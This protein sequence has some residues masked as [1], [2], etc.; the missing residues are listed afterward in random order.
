MAVAT[1]AEAATGPDE[2]QT[3]D[4]LDS[5]SHGPQTSA[6]D[7]PEA[8][9]PYEAQHTAT[10]HSNLSSNSNSGANSGSKLLSSVKYVAPAVAAL[11]SAW[12]FRRRRSSSKKQQPQQQE[13]QQQFES[14][15]E[16]LPEPE[17]TL[18]VYASDFTCPHSSPV[19]TAGSRALEGLGMVVSEHIPIQ[20]S[21]E[22]GISPVYISL[23]TLPG[24]RQQDV[25]FVWYIAN[26]QLK[27]MCA[28]VGARLF[29]I[30]Q[31]NMQYVAEKKQTR[32][33]KCTDNMGLRS[34][35]CWQDICF[36][37]I[38]KSSIRGRMGSTTD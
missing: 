10:T 32:A 5:P 1:T 19:G 16:P 33:S 14:P 24:R 23:S 13:E 38:H 22:D 29:V 26:Q 9:D 17:P 12:W 18:A 37:I 30:S 27:H 21:K 20:V 2:V 15:P 28:L 34:D 35:G 3:E 4:E 25:S 6:S 8:S 36:K 7:L 11:A 31:T